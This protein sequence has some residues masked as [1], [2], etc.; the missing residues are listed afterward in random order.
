MLHDA[1]VDKEVPIGH[2]RKACVTLSIQNCPLVNSIWLTIL[3]KSWYV[4][5]DQR[6]QNDSSPP[7]PYT[8]GYSTTS[9]STDSFP[10]LFHFW[11]IIDRVPLR[12][13]EIM[14]LV[15]SIHLSVSLYVLLLACK[16]TAITLKKEDHLCNQARGQCGSWSI[17]SWTQLVGV[18][19]SAFSNIPIRY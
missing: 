14:H 18:V 13:R 8:L 1:T 7:S 16:Q 10:Q 6:M 12:S 2:V 17:M 4:S 9:K 5:Q 15:V 11:F 3:V 19:D